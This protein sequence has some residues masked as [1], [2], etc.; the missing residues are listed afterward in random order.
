MSNNNSGNTDNKPSDNSKTTQESTS[1]YKRQPDTSRM[2]YDSI[3]GLKKR[4]PS[5]KQK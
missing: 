4:P 1:Q 3:D 2:V 5:D